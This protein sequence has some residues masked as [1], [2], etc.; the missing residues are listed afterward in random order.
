MTARP[1]ERDTL[2]FIALKGVGGMPGCLSYIASQDPSCPAAIRITGVRDSPENHRASLSLP[3]IQKAIALGRPLI[4]G[5]DASIET[6]PV[7]GHGL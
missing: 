4:A 1:G 2:I 3:S 7:R 5:M 6:V